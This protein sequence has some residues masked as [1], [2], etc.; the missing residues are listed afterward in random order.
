[1]SRTTEEIITQIKELIESEVKPAVAQHG[2]VINFVSY[3]TGRL[4]LELS[5][6]CA[7]CAGSRM[8]LKLGVEKM[9]KLRVP[10]LEVVDAVNDVNSNVKPYYTEED[11]NDANSKEV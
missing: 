6:A 8:T 5:G 7:G 2:G 9:L 1:M 10:E 4:L 3:D 11:L